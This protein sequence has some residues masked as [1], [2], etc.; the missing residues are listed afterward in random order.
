MPHA[1]HGG[2]WHTHAHST[3]S[4]HLTLPLYCPFCTAA[5]HPLPRPRQVAVS[6]AVDRILPWLQRA[7][8]VVV[9][10]GL[11]DDPAVGGGGSSSN[12]G[13]GG[14]GGSSSS[15]D[16]GCWAAELVDWG[17]GAEGLGPMG[18]VAYLQAVDS[19]LQ[20]MSKGCRLKQMSGQSIE[21]T[22]GLWGIWQ[23]DERQLGS[24]AVCLAVR[25]S[26]H[27]NGDVTTGS[28]AKP[29]VCEAGAALL[30][31]ARALGLPVVIDGSALTHIIAQVSRR[32]GTS[33]MPLLK[34]RPL[35]AR[36][37]LYYGTRGLGL[38]CAGGL[39]SNQAGAVRE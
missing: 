8:A 11:G 10:P 35:L 21:R 31:H 20:D 19:G 4:R 14:G 12:G 22:D 23:T 28:H 37:L 2:A 3:P 29:Q 34:C 27:G 25:V 1:W 15:G 26:N 6:R 36:K 18:G 33:C 13:D 5:W 32:C 7:T 39:D 17:W 16:G 9:G 38:L 30:H 24:R